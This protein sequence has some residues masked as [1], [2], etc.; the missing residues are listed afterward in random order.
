[1]SL[2]GLATLLDEH[3]ARLPP[4]SH[5]A[6]DG[7][8]AALRAIGVE[9]PPVVEQAGPTAAATRAAWR[10]RAERREK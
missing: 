10:K 4:L 5:A 1:M 6:A 9:P 2:L 8:R 7:M 3:A